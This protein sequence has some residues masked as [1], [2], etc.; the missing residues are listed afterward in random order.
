MAILPEKKKKRAYGLLMPP[1][2]VALPGRPGRAVP[3]SL[4]PSCAVLCTVWGRDG[5][6]ESPRGQASL[7][8]PGRC[9]NSPK[10]VFPRRFAA[11]GARRQ[12]R[13]GESRAAI[14]ATAPEPGPRGSRRAGPAISAPAP[15][16][17][18]AR[19]H[20]LASPRWALGLQATPGR[21]TAS[22]P[23]V[24]CEEA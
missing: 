13:V 9:G 21:L 23:R 10:F 18:A 16:R 1:G 4:S 22:G 14:S 6:A 11:V 3:G 12:R 7:C 20:P 19:A 8:G 5:V 2:E 24:R 17:A 15:R